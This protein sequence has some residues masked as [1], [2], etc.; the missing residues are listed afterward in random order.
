MLDTSHLPSSTKRNPWS[1]IFLVFA[2]AFAGSLFLLF[3]FWEALYRWGELK[4]YA[5]PIAGGV[6]YYIHVAKVTLGLSGVNSQLAAEYYYTYRPFL[7]QEGIDGRLFTEF[8]GR[9]G[10]AFAVA[11]FIASRLY[12]K[13]GWEMYRHVS[14][15]RL[16]EGKEAI[17]EGKKKF[18]KLVKEDE[19]GEGIRV[20]PTLP[21]PFLFERLNFFAIGAP[22]SGKTNAMVPMVQTALDRGDK[23]FLYDPPKGEMVEQF[24]DRNTTILIAPTDPRS[25]KWAIAS[26]CRTELDA[27]D[28][29]ER[30]IPKSNKGGD[31]MWP[32][33]ARL[34]FTGLLVY[35]QN[36]R[37]DKWGWEHLEQAL[38]YP[39]DKLMRVFDEHY[40]AA[41]AFIEEES[42]TTQ[43]ILI[44][45][46]AYTGFVKVLAKAWPQSWKGFSVRRWAI[47]NKPKKPLLIVQA[48][49]KLK[50]LSH[51]LVR[52]LHSLAQN[53]QYQLPN[54]KSRRFWFFLDEIGTIYLPD[55]KEGMSLLAGKGVCYFL[56]VQD[57]SMIKGEY[58]DE[59]FNAIQSMI[60][61]VLA[62]GVAKGES[63]Q[64]LSETIGEREI[65]RPQ[66]TKNGTSVSTSW[67]N[68]RIPVLPPEKFTDELSI[69]TGYMIPNGTGMVLKLRWPK[70]DVPV[71]APGK[72]QIEA[73]WVRRVEREIQQL[74]KRKEELVTTETRKV[75]KQEMPDP[76]NYM[77]S[78]KVEDMVSEV[79]PGV[80]GD[81][82]GAGINAL[83]VV[84]IVSDL[85]AEDETEVTTVSAKTAP[86]NKLE[87][88]KKKKKKLQ[89]N[90]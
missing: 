19:Y 24:Y 28:I 30:F 26:D 48:H 51:G 42:V 22:R 88:L 14:G 84:D 56:G 25:S 46:K 32:N 45:V 40:P 43:G 78:Q 62:F 33:A 52:V 23:V 82:L 77:T 5:K 49:P 85:M 11:F 15:P 53:E 60:R 63:A 8:F 64:W 81:V 66:H 16:F 13:G 79:V 50:E 21:F 87:A 29:A 57:L 75:E 39:A 80:A 35:L 70:S 17:C 2:F 44:N 71:R 41:R 6:M 18:R 47:A 36:T 61:T 55:L 20:H 34:V 76:E 83:N 10:I 37:G 74:E 7:Q 65:E 67:H 59:E 3:W 1:V 54:S 86:N 58:G 31:D 68:Q 4:Q 69:G 9:V 90:Q 12:K 89:Q 38:N 27:E 73:K 72:G